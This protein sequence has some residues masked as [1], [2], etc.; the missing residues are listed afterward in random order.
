M[1]DKHTGEIHL[2]TS[3]GR[4]PFT[5]C[6]SSRKST[7]GEVHLLHQ[8]FRLTAH[9]EIGGHVAERLPLR[10]GRFAVGHGQFEANRWGRSARM[11]RKRRSFR[12]N[13]WV[14]FCIQRGRARRRFGDI[15]KRR[16]G[17][18]TGD[19]QGQHGGREQAHGLCYW[20]VNLRQFHRFRCGVVGKPVLGPLAHVLFHIEPEQIEVAFMPIFSVQQLA[21]NHL[22]TCDFEHPV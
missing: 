10:D 9:G 5:A 3:G 18:G 7:P 22:G 11:R 15:E 16:L 12:R 8:A 17:H 21:A 19:G 2:L 20:S 13:P 4:R 14:S 1:Q 6:P